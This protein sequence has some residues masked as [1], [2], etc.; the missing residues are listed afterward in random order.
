[1]RV[2]IAEDDAALGLYLKRGLEAEGYMVKWVGDGQSAVDAFVEDAPDLT[3][4]DLNLPRKDGSDVLRFLRS[5]SDEHPILVLTARQELDTKIKCLDGGADDCMIKPFSLDELRARCRSLVRRRRD[6]NLVLRCAGVELN[7]VDHTVKRDGRLI[8]LTAKEYALLEYLL[9]Q[10]GACVSRT[11]LLE[12]VWNMGSAAG[13]N[14]VDVYIN[15]L[16]RKMQDS[17]SNSMIET[18]RGQG[19]RIARPTLG[20]QAN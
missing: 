20:A 2:L 11:K 12:Q 3:I 15:Y 10:R 16:R 14:V 13:T 8:S 7:R 19:Y 9:L 5:S 1:M 18:V 17:P 4:L 6:I